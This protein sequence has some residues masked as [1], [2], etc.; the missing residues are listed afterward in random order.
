VATGSNT[1]GECNVPKW[2]LAPRR[3][4]LALTC[5]LC[6]IEAKNFLASFSLALYFTVHGAP[7]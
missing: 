5:H 4:Q 2:W 7:Q 3:S 1:R 6:N